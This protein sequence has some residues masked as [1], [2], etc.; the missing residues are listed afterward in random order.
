MHS[1]IGCP[2]DGGRQSQRN[3]DKFISDDGLAA[4]HFTAVC[5]KVKNNITPIFQ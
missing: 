4:Y 5:L 2:F 1:S 3:G